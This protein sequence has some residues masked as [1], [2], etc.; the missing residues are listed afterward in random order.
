MLFRSRCLTEDLSPAD[1]FRITTTSFMDAW[2]FDIRQLMKSCVH[3]VLPSGHLIPFCA[4]NLL[5]RDG[6]VA[7]P[8][9]R[10]S[11]AKQAKAD[12]V[13]LGGAD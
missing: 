1:V 6:R 8:A 9:L 10:G 13:T 2:N 11:A 7:L 5:Y 4:Y 3:H 12:L